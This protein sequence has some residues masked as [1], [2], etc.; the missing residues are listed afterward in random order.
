[1]PATTVLITGATGFVGGHIIDANLRKKHKV[2][3]LVMPGDPMETALRNKKVEICY[4]DLRDAASLERA[5]K[6]VAVIFH[7]AAVVTDWAP[8]ALFDA[9]HLQG[10][11]NICQAALKAR[12]KRFVMISTN[13]VFGLS[14]ESVMDEAAPLT[15]WHEP[16]PDTKIEAEKIAW[17]YYRAHKLPVTMVYPCWIY[18][19]GDRTF[20]PLTAD[21]ILKREMV[22]WR[23]N[24]HVWPTYVENLVDL[25]MKI[26]T[27]KRA[28]GNGYLVHDG[29]MTTYQA[30]CAAI[31]ETVGAK[32][33]RLH[34][35]YFLAYAAAAMLEFFWRLFGKKSR[36]LITTYT[37]K[38][39]GS[40]LRFSI[41]KAQRDLNWKPPISYKEGLKRTLVWLKTLDR[42]ALKMK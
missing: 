25:L 5:A 38:N 31:A 16:Y 10:T 32:P 3:V 2:R 14:E 27:D 21:A 23:R 1:M 7:C 41:A 26:S 24:V 9:V 18:G 37:V 20:V 29:E 30:F 11:E 8:R 19:P 6:G 34:I 42:A 36:P 22:F 4:G 15:P 13:D 28:V 12:V 39:L 35:P 33:P 40:R 17:R